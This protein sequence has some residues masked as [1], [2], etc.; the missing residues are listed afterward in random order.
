[1]S[2][3]TYTGKHRNLLEE[4]PQHCHQLKLPHPILTN[5]DV[6][7]LR[8]IRRDDFRVAV[9]PAVFDAAGDQPGAAL[10]RALGEL[11]DTAQTAIEA[12][13]SLLILSDRG[14]SPLKASIP[15]LLATAAL[16]PGLLRRRLRGEVGI[17][18]ESGEPREVMHFCLLC[19]Y[20][21]NAV[22]PYVAFEAIHKLHDD[23][24]LPRDVELDQLNDQF[25][26]AVKKGILKT[27][28]KMGI[29]TLRSYHAAQ[30]FE[31]VGLNRDL[32]DEYFTG[33]PSRIGGI[34]IDVVAREALARHRA[35][36]GSRRAGSLELDFEGEYH[37]RLDGERHL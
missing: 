14:V 16:H 5:E 26:T 31:A 11:V 22:N 19:G 6:E 13:A 37:H 17:V 2:L 24:D 28:S 34:G 25:I 18:V 12:G 23:G 4:T 3:M 15:C 10:R 21:A 35:A 32:V 20:G 29:S 30:Q 7:R 33:T 36:F 9:I 27:M 8:S 1:M